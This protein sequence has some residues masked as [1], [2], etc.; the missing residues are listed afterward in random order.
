[1]WKETYT[2]YVTLLR[3]GTH[4]KFGVGPRQRAKVYGEPLLEVRGR[5]LDVL[6]WEQE[7]LG[8]THPADPDIARALVAH[9][10][11]TEVRQD[12]VVMEVIARC[13]ADRF[14]LEVT[15]SRS[16]R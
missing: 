5:R 15:S 16:R 13:A 14:G 2:G 4:V 6:L 7:C 12:P 3:D 9:G 11:Y 1:M 10:G 8:D